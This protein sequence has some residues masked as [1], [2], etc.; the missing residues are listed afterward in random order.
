M[1]SSSAGPIDRG[2][3]R[4]A[5]AHRGKL[6]RNRALYERGGFRKAAPSRRERSS[7]TRG[8]PP[9]HLFT[10]RDRGVG[11][12]GKQAIDPELVIHRKL[13]RLVAA[14][15]QE[16]RAALVAYAEV[17]RKEVVLRTEREWVQ[18]QPDA[19]ASSTSPVGWPNGLPA[20]LPATM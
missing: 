19:M 6:A 13:G 11:V 20:V 4:P 15:M 3:G 5:R 12:V 14:G 18:E 9:E 1:T 7:A 10:H 8:R 2:S 17:R 16:F